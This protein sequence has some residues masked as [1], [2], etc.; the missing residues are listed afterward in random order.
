MR[1]EKFYLGKGEFVLSEMTGN[2]GKH[3]WK[4]AVLNL[5]KGHTAP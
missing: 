5:F 2:L 4:G 3:A 1:A